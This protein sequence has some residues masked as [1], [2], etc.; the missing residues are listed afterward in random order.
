MQDFTQQGYNAIYEQD[1]SFDDALAYVAD[2]SNF[3]S[4]YA[5][6][7]RELRRLDCGGSDEEMFAAFK[8]LAKDAN[9]KISEFV[10][11]EEPEKGKAFRWFY[12][13]RESN[14]ECLP[15]REH[16]IKL[17]FAFKLNIE[18]AAN[19]LWKVCRLNGF[20]YRRAKDVIYCYCLENHLSFSTVS[21]I[22]ANFKNYKTEQAAPV[23]PHITRTQTIRDRF[24][25]LKGL[26]QAEF[27]AML[28]ADKHNF[29]DYSR[30]AH[31]EMKAVYA[32]VLAEIEKERALGS[33]SAWLSDTVEVKK[34]DKNGKFVT[35]YETKKFSEN[36]NLKIVDGDEF[37]ET[38]GD[39]DEFTYEF[40]CRQLSE[41]FKDEYA[42]EIAIRKLTPNKVY[43]R[44]VADLASFL[45]KDN[46]SKAIASKEYATETER[47]CARKLFVFLK[48]A[49]SVLKW[50]RFLF[51]PNEKTS[52][53]GK[54]RAK[55]MSAKNCPNI[56]ILG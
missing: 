52:L 13:S 6:I 46:L 10:C 8:Q 33:R 17:C 35:S 29:L 37:R 28:C 2:P 25:K 26:P 18:Q 44:Y 38:I 34:K 27:E 39:G 42:D 7:T 9:V 47:G 24:G 21:V 20:C 5:G 30:T 12:T 45:T 36:G 53:R 50:E 51:N 1:L 43:C 14:E 11:R 48:F 54:L 55:A 19:F 3:L 31:D 32:E 49:V 40:I 22:I 4:V 23:E 56:F 16:A 41:R 15:T